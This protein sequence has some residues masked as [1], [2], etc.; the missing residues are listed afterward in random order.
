V[1]RPVRW[2]SVRIAMPQALAQ[3][4]DPSC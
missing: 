3:A 2:G 1:Q 4:W